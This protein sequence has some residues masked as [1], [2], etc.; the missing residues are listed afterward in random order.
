MKHIKCVLCVCVCVR[1][2]TCVRV[3]MC[4]RVCTY[5]VFTKE[6]IQIYFTNVNN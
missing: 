1:V 4:V 2:C 6:N 3:C 5:T